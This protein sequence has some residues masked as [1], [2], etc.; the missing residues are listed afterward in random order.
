M[1]NILAKLHDGLN[2]PMSL[3][4]FEIMID[5]SI[6]YARYPE[7]ADDVDL[8]VNLA[9]KNMYREKSISAGTFQAASE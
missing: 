8:L 5:A 6:G 7:D 4:D 2:Q 1:D 3:G 9:D